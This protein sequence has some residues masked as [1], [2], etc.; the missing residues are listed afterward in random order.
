MNLKVNTGEPL[1][2]LRNQRRDQIGIHCRERADHEAASLRSMHLPYELC[3]P[4]KFTDCALR[5]IVEHFPGLSE[6]HLS[7]EPIKQPATQLVFQ[8]ANLHRQ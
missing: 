6:R 1:F 3:S 8:R 4:F 7:P 5:M 2:E